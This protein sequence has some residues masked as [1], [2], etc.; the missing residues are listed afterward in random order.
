MTEKYTDWNY[1]F[2]AGY[3]AGDI[4]ESTDRMAMA[5]DGNFSPAW[6]GW[7]AHPPSFT[8]F[9]IMSKVV[10]S[11]PAE[12]A[13]TLLQ[14]LLLPFSPLRGGLKWKLYPVHRAGIFK[15]SMGA[16]NREEIGLSY[17]PA[18]LLML[19]EF[20]HGWVLKSHKIENFFGS[21][22][23]FCTISLLLL[24]KY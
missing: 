17:R 9:T 23:E 24:L 15:Q 19:V 22:F 7:G 13:D 8:L 12:R 16:R 2:S 10:V 18:M 14:F 21:D 4:R 6:W 20:V 3:K 11:A 1:T 5:N